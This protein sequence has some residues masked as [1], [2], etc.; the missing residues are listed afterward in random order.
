MHPG[1]L[2]VSFLFAFSS[3]LPNV[4]HAFVI[5]DRTWC[6]G[7]KTT[8]HPTTSSLI[9]RQAHDPSQAPAHHHEPLL[10]ESDELIKR[11]F[12][13]PRAVVVDVR[14]PLE[15]TSKVKARHWINAPGSPFYNEKLACSAS[16]LIPNKSVPVIVYCSSGKRA[17]AAVEVLERQGYTNVHNAGGIDH[18]Y[19]LPVVKVSDHQRNDLTILP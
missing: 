1:L 16:Q 6:Y 3:S 4:S 9:P 5:V 11:A 19:F 12:H 8:Q 15:I 7:A 14:S 17:H 10:V 18:L 2:S 13:D